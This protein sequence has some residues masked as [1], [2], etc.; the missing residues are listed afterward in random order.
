MYTNTRIYIIK[1]MAND[2]VCVMDDGLEKLLED[3]WQNQCWNIVECAFIQFIAFYVSSYYS[4]VY[5]ICIIIIQLF[6]LC[7]ESEKVFKSIVL[8]NWYPTTLMN[9]FA[10]K[11]VWECVSE[12]CGQPVTFWL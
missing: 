2:K 8:V 3:F 1:Y 10:R 12:R 11:G 4:F 6:M 9:F 5:I 7:V